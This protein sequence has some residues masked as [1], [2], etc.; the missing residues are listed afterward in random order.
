MGK[1]A[2]NNGGN[3]PSQCPGE[4]PMKMEIR[5]PKRERCYLHTS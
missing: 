2:Q 1:E 4:S 5:T 3:N